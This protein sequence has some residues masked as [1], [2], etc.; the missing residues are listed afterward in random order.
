MRP[1]FL[2]PRIGFWCSNDSNHE[3]R[4]QMM[5]RLTAADLKRFWRSDHYGELSNN[6][7]S[8]PAIV[9]DTPQ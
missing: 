1:T 7:L 3:S 8:R 5:H 2:R 6:V 4:P 9:I